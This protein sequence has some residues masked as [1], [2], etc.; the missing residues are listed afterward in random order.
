MAR[1]GRVEF[2]VNHKEFEQGLNLTIRKVNRGTRKATV[3]AS[4][5]ILEAS[6]K[7]VPR[8]TEALASSAYVEISG[9]SKNNYREGFAAEIGYGAKAGSVNPKSGEHPSEYMITVHEDLEVYHKIGKAKF[10]EDPVRDYQRKLAPR[11]A[12][13]VKNET[14]M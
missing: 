7:E 5:E 12:R 1:G 14:G 13:F 11:F 3:A 10:L 6:L 2:N 8:D 4:N 9:S